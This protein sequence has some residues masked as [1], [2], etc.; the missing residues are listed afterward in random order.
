MAEAFGEDLK[1]IQL[2]V[3]TAP[4]TSTSAP[5]DIVA[6]QL[7]DESA[8]TVSFRWDTTGLQAGRHRVGVNLSCASGNPL[9]WYEQSPHTYL[10][11]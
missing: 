10:L 7:V 9:W 11:L 5:W 4:D 1:S 2:V 3:N 6:T 8:A